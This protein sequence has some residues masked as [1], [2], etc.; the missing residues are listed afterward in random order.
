MH[1]VVPAV[2]RSKMVKLIH[3]LHLGMVTSKQPARDFLFWHGMNGQ[4][5]EAV[6]KCGI[7]LKY[8][9]KPARSP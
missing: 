3:K 6:R 9:N 8:C 5:D 4:I 2:M 7:G 1:I